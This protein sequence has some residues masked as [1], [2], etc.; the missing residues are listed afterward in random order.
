MPFRIVAAIL[1]S[2]LDCGGTAIAQDRNASD[3]DTVFLV[4]H[5]GFRDA[6]YFHTVLI[7]API[8]SGGHIG[9]IINRPTNR[10]LCSF[11]PEHEPSKKVAE[12]VRYSKNGRNLVLLRGAQRGPVHRAVRP[13]AAAR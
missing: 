13:E 3:E 12:P 1:L 9:V 10:S 5:P 11:F 7:A 4:A 8:P 2:I 6:G